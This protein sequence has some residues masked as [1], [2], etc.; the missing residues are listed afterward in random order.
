MKL[1]FVID[2]KYDKQFLGMS[3]KITRDHF[4]DIYRNSLRYLKYTKEQYQIAWDEI[5]SKF[6]AILKKKQDI[7]GFIRII[8]VLFQSQIMAFQIG[9]M[10][11]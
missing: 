11:L 9:D 3:N 8:N 2:K 7:N 5:G 1:E 6:F 4:D 10:L